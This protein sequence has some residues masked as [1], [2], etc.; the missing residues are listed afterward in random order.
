MALSSELIRLDGEVGYLK[1]FYDVTRCRQTEEQ[2]R[3]AISEVVSDTSWFSHKV[4][5]RLANI[6]SGGGTKETVELTRWERQI[7]ERLASGQNNEAIA[8]GLAPQT[9]RNYISA[10]YRKLGVNSR[11][12]ASG[13]G[14][15]SA[16]RRPGVNR[17]GSGRRGRASALPAACCIPPSSP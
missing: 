3:R 8:A 15:S 10:V 17:R 13:S 1:M 9:V 6:R 12:E 2:M 14:E 7:L 4:M 16:V 11:A 5:E